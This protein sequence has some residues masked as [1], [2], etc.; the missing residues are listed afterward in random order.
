MR[1]EIISKFFFFFLLSFWFGLSDEAYSKNLKLKHPYGILGESFGI[2][3]SED[4]AINDCQAEPMPFAPESTSYQ[5]WQCFELTRSKLY[6]DGNKFDKTEK[7]RVTMMVI[8]EKKDEQTNEYLARRPI[9][10]SS[11]KSYLA[12][13]REL[14]RNEKYVCVSGSL[15][16]QQKNEA[17]QLISHWT[18]DRFKTLRGCQSYFQGGC[19]L[20]YQLSHDCISQSTK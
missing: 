13:W 4:V 9:P 3:N 18:F 14:T 12:D 15:I 20:K 8:S 7:T 1:K 19:S 6:C 10:L 17:G 5:Y 16:Y 11:C 2:L